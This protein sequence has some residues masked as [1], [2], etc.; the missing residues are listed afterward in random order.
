MQMFPCDYCI[1]SISLTSSLCGGERRIID[2]DF[3]TD[4]MCV[5][6]M[7]SFIEDDYLSEM[8]FYDVSTMIH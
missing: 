5:E 6:D 2:S 4:S 7:S 8:D 3:S 1:G